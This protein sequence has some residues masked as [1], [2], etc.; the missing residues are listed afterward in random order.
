M[1]NMNN[2][3]RTHD[4]KIMKNSAPSTTKLAIA[5]EK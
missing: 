2:V 5:F 1:P 4:S 3:I